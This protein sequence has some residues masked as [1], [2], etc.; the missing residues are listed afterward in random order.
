[1]TTIF[2][3]P[4]WQFSLTEEDHQLVRRYERLAIR[5]ADK[6]R[7]SS[8]LTGRLSRDDA[9]QYALCVLCRAAKTYDESLGVRFS[10]YA[11]KL[12]LAE[13]RNFAGETT[14]AARMPTYWS[15]RESLEG[16]SRYIGNAKKLAKASSIHRYDD[17]TC[18]VCDRAVSDEECRREILRIINSLPPREAEAVYARFFEG[19][20]WGRAKVKA[21][22]GR[23]RAKQICERAIKR[24]K[25]MIED[26]P[27]L[28]EM[29]DR[30]VNRK[31]GV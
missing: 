28:V 11:G 6:A 26:S 27:I 9:V 4:R 10:T 22:Y 20:K 29:Y 13:L 31:A 1:M 17:Q 25:R 12:I 30:V 19:E 3:A 7:A 14:Y 21:G 16:K 2:D 8:S 24:L 5:M 23:V 15:N 18:N